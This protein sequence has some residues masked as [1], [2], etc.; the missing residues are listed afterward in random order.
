MERDSAVW[1]IAA[2]FAVQSVIRPEE[3]R[4]YL[5]RML[6]VHQLRLTSGVG[7][8]LMRAWPTSYEIFRTTSQRTT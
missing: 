7:Q 4:D 5:I 8:H 6:E 3:T 1:D 2:I